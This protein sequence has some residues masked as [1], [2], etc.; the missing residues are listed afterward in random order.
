MINKTMFF[1]ISA[2][3]ILFIIG[4]INAYYVDVDYAY[5]RSNS[6]PEFLNTQYANYF[7]NIDFS[8]QIVG[9]GLTAM[10]KVYVSPVIY[11]IKPNGYFTQVMVVPTTSIY[12]YPGAPYNYIYNNLFYFDEDY[13]SYN[14]VLNVTDQTGNQLTNDSAYVYSSGSNQGG[15]NSGGNNGTPANNYIPTCSDFYVSGQSDIY[16]QEDDSATYDLY[17]INTI[18]NELTITSVTT[19]NPENLS[20]DNIDY[21]YNVGSY[22]TRSV[23]LDLTSETVDD[24]YLGSFIVNVNGKYGSL[25]C[26]KTYTVY[27]HINDSSNSSNADCS[28]IEIDNESI[29]INEDSTLTKTLIIENKSFDYEYVIDDATIKDGSEVDADVT[30]TP[31]K[32]N[33]DSSAN[34]KIKFDT[35]IVNQD[36]TNELRLTI[37]GYMKRNGHEDKHCKKYV[38]LTVKVIDN[39]NN[40]NNDC[41]LIEIHS[42]MVSQAENTTKD[43]NFTNGFY[44]LNKSNNKFIISQISL[45]DNSKFAEITKNSM[46]S[47]INANSQFSLNFRIKASQ[48]STTETSISNISVMGHFENGETCTYSD[49]RNSFTL[50][51]LDSSNACSKISVLDQ[52]VVLGE[53]TITLQNSTDKEFIV[54][55]IIVLNKNGLN[56]NVIDKSTSISLNSRKNVRINVEGNGSATLQ[57]AGKFKNGEVCSYQQTSPGLITTKEIINFQDSGCDYIIDYPQEIELSNS[58]ENFYLSFRN[59]T[60]KGGI[61]NI[62]TLGSVIDTP[63]IYLEGEDDFTRALTIDNFDNPTYIIYK[64]KLNDCSEDIYSTKINSLISSDKKIVLA[65]YPGIITPTK[66]RFLTNVSIL[67]TYNTDKDVSIKLAGF[68]ID[69]KIYLD[70]SLMNVDFIDST[71]NSKTMFTINKNQTKTIYFAIIVPETNTKTKYNGY[72]EVYDGVN[73]Q[74]I[75]KNPFSID[76]TPISKDI[77]V[78]S[79]TILRENDFENSY[80]LEIILKNNNK[81]SKDYLVV[82]NKN[83]DY[84]IDGNKEFN[85][86]PIDNNISLEYKMITKKKLDNKT[87]LPFSIIEINSNK[88]IITDKFIYLEENNNRNKITAFLSIGTVPGIMSLIILIIICILIIRY[89]IRRIKLKRKERGLRNSQN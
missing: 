4:N 71:T 13:L 78:I 35:D 19:T 73:A 43:Y 24:D 51:L 33:E 8:Y 54:N 42:S 26:T 17:L 40:K 61:I 1:T 18:E 70:D 82:F 84:V 69:W 25:N 58:K 85:L 37:D 66:N 63:V 55:D 2:I 41:S 32:V 23:N 86:I 45:N 56:I 9:Y 47:S 15:G 12:L 14:L 81:I 88:D 57:I 83:N 16:L 62:S 87:E 64:V 65:S 59:N 60:I 79:K 75:S 52:K 29:T 7:D 30:S 77:E 10:Q 74:L 3:A 34:I 31:S 6:Y 67:N 20:I 22:A 68:P 44:I 39:S 5:V 11:G 27:Y 53:N 76:F 46:N 72:F 49:I 80:N 89:I 38:D 36:I 21:P 48:V 50:N 28:D